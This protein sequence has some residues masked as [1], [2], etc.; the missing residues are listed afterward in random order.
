[1]KNCIGIINLDENENRMG[2]LVV[3]RSLASV[4]IA[5]RYRVIDFV[6]SNMTNSGVNCIGIFTKNKSRSLIDHLTNGRPWDLNRKKDGL[7]VFN[8]GNDEPVYDDVHNFAEN[9]QFLTHSR[10]EYVLLA[11]SYMICNIDY[12]EVLEYHKS[13]GKDITMVYKKVN[14]ADEAFGD[15]GVLNFDDSESVI[16]VGENIGKN[17]KANINMEMYILKA[18]LFINIVNDCVSS[19]MYRKVKEYI[20][21]NLNALTVGAYE[22]KGHLDCINSIKALYDSNVGFLNRKINKEIFNEERP[23]YTKTKDE[24]PT[25]YADKSNVVNSIIANGCRIEGTVENCIIGRRVYIGKNTKLKDC[26][27]MQN[28]K[29]DDEAV[30]DN[31]IADKGSEIRK[32]ETLI[33]SIMYPLVIKKKK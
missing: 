20:H 21:N 14:N 16:S 25:H 30:L 9:I 1:M 15:C 23:I 31:V 27:I 6:L 26:I 29:I 33:G 8:F 32:G 4:P 5:A 7:K 17:P 28:S 2:E 10:R 11:P 12:N 19:G 13:T 3:N 22:F 24:A 18:D